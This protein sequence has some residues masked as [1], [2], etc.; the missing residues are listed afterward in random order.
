MGPK[1]QHPHS[2]RGGPQVPHEPH[3]LA[4]IEITDPLLWASR[5][6]YFKVEASIRAD[7]EKE[8]GEEV[9]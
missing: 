7:P 3:A 4:G 8:G 9:H 1:C 5:G 2:Q 6:K